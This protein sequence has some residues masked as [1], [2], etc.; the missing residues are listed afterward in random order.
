[1]DDKLTGHYDQPTNVFGCSEEML[2]H[3]AS[4]IAPADLQAALK[5]RACRD[6]RGNVATASLFERNYLMRPSVAQGVAAT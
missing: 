3:W 4:H 5:D 2:G 1:M 6:L